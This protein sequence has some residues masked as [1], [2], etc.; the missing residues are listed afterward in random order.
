MKSFTFWEMAG[1]PEW[2]RQAIPEYM[3]HGLHC[4]RGRLLDSNDTKKSDRR[5]IAWM[6]KCENDE[7]D[8][9]TKKAP[10]VNH[11]FFTLTSDFGETSTRLWR[12]SEENKTKKS[13]ST[14]L[15]TATAWKLLAVKIYQA[16]GI[17][18]V[19]RKHMWR[20]CTPQERTHAFHGILW[21]QYCSGSTLATHEHLV[22][23]ESFR[24]MIYVQKVYSN[25][26]RWTLTNNQKRYWLQAASKAIFGAIRWTVREQFKVK[27]RKFKLDFSMLKAEVAR[28]ISVLSWK[29]WPE[30]EE[31]IDKS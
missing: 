11:I 27:C 23:R 20:S 22:E 12:E 21:S 24:S 19:N 7:K 15:Y 8:T 5:H 4:I 6:K 3:L 1:C 9:H 25:S 28:P 10:Q 18:L 31:M 17:G 16:L 30:Q 29:W 14:I 13:S 2:M 26:S